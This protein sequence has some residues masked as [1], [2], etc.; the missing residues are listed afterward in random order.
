MII[1]CGLSKKF[2]PDTSYIND[3]G[4][5]YTWNDN[6]NNISFSY[7]LLY[8]CPCAFRISPKDFSLIH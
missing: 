2:R 4:T 3:S 6:T 8:D 7:N 1:P 5:I